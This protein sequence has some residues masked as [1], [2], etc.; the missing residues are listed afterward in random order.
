MN[1]KG[2][3]NP[4]NAFDAHQEATQE[5]RV[6]PDGTIAVNV[7]SQEGPRTPEQQEAI[8]NR[9][10]TLRHRLTHATEENR[11]EIEE[12]IAIIEKHFSE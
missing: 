7:S 3:N 6:S 1:F 2:E 5:G 8:S 4:W 12:E 11:S 10:R 9:L